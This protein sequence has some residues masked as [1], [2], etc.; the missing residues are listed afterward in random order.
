VGSAYQAT[1][2]RARGLAGLDWAEWAKI[3][4]SFSLEFLMPFIFIFSMGFKSNSNQIS[5]SKQ[6]KHVHQIKE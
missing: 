5:N 4:F 2:A 1:R 6:F 3:G